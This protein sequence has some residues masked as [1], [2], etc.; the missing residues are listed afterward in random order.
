M[1]VHIPSFERWDKN[2]KRFEHPCLA[3][4]AQ[5]SKVRA[6][7]APLIASGD[8][9][10]VIPP[11]LISK[12]RLLQWY[13]G[14]FVPSFTRRPGHTIALSPELWVC[15]VCESMEEETG[16][17]CFDAISRKIRRIC[18]REM[19]VALAA[20]VGV[21]DVTNEMKERFQPFGESV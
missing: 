10:S 20:S 9:G 14:I 4:I 5:F 8:H 6:S 3:A 2:D 15:E 13:K 11:G 7:V 18:K 17:P 19:G 12:T 16:K 21:Q 1:S